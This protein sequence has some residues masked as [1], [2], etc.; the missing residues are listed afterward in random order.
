MCCLLSCARACS[1]MTHACANL[2]Y[3]KRACAKLAT[4]GYAKHAYAFTCVSHVVI[5]YTGHC[6]VN[7]EVDVGSVGQHSTEESMAQVKREGEIPHI[8][9]LL[10]TR[11]ALHTHVSHTRL[12]IRMFHTRTLRIALCES[13]STFVLLTVDINSH[14][15]AIQGPCLYEKAGTDACCLTC[16]H[17]AYAKPRMQSVRMWQRAGKDKNMALL[18][19]FCGPHGSARD[20]SIS[21]LCTCGMRCAKPRMRNRRV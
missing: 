13:F 1:C 7:I 18:A 15:W 21:V 19:L 9:V 14:P 16:K 8:S 11:R 2:P 3:A 12:R 5:V 17:R 20:P 6:M 4:K 10:D